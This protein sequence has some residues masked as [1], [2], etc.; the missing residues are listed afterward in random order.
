MAREIMEVE[1]DLVSSQVEAHLKVWKESK[2]I[3]I[4]SE[5]HSRS[6]R[7]CGLV[8][9]LLRSWGRWHVT[10]KECSLVKVGNPAEIGRLWIGSASLRSHD[11]FLVQ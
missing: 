6:N 7:Y 4:L 8:I 3:L 2:E 9:D 11:G 10:C 5:I 1:P